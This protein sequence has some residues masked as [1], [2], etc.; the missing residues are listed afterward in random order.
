MKLSIRSVAIACALGCAVLSQAAQ[1]INAFAAHPISSSADL[2]RQINSESLV[3]QRYMLHF[4]MAK[5]EIVKYVGTLQIARLEQDGLYTVYE[6]PDGLTVKSQV[7]TL[8]KGETVLEDALGNAVII[9]TSGNPLTLGPVS[10]GMKSKSKIA[11]VASGSGEINGSPTLMSE[12]TGTKNAFAS[13]DMTMSA[14]SQPVS[15]V[16][17]RQDS[18]P[19]TATSSSISSLGTIVGLA[20][21][22]AVVVS[23]TNN[24][25]SHSIRLGVVPEPMTMIALGAGLVAV[26]RRKKKSA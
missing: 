13:A 21:V 25:S 3:A 2:A 8:R 11:V 16:N 5:A 14:V 23:A 19:A 18:A 9:A 10:E 26:A 7:Q 1:D 15:L 22:G 12:P 24:S 6:V 17:L 20:A 4:G